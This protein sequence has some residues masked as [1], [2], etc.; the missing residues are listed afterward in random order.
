M[1]KKQTLKNGLRFITVPSKNTK[2]VTVLVMI[3][4]GSKYEDKNINGISH[5]LEHMFFK[6]TKKRPTPLAIS[7]ELDKVGGVYNAFTGEEY[8]G[9]L[10]KVDSGHLDLALDVISDILLNSKFDPE[11]IERERGVIVEELNMYKDTPMRY[12]MELFQQLLYGDQPA[13]RSTIG[14][15]KVINSLKRK[16]FIEY[17]RSHYKTSNT[18]ICISGN[19]NEKTLKQKVV[20]YFHPFSKGKAKN[21]KKVKEIQKKP[22]SLIE[23]KK[24]DQTHL[25][26]GARA[27]HMSDPRRFAT[28]ILSVILGGNMSSRLF[29]NLRER[30]GLA[31]Y[32]RTMLSQHTDSGYLVTHTGVRNDNIEKSIKIIIDEYKNIRDN[33]IAENELE[34]AKN[35]I[36][37]AMLIGLES[38]DSKAEFFTE[39]EI[40]K[41]KIQTP[42]EIIENINK[43][44]AKDVQA[45]AEDIFRLEKLNLALIGPFKNSKKFQ[46]LL[47]L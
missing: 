8:T 5:F 12:V 26:L 34:K 15:K 33:G 20:K 31:Y 46:N 29:T 14:T 10:A 35:Y 4:T 36:K 30:M 27:Y 23:F 43:V 37:G 42:E 3:A 47:I 19:F 24:T 22:M 17:L 13:G 40:L 25:C 32:V 2:T 44:S 11:E 39:Q 1:Y 7:E 21:K 9:Y 41:N 18:V 45:V 38:S 16:D 6:G 28:S